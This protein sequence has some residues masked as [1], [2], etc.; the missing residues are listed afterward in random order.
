VLRLASG[1]WRRIAVLRPG[2]IG[3]YL[4]ATPAVRALR[5]AVPEARLDYVALPLIRELVERNPQ[6]DRFVAFPGFPSIAE[7]F[8][9]ARRAVR[10]LAAMQRQRYDLVLQL[11]GSGVHANPIALLMGPRYCAGFIRPE[12]DAHG[13]DEA[14]PLPSS[15]TEVDRV[16]ALTRLL[17][18]PDAGRWYDLELRPGDRAD[19]GRWLESLPR[20]VV[21]VHCGARDDQRRVEP[22]AYSQAAAILVASHGG[23]VAIL[24]GE[25]ERAAAVAL[26]AALR[27]AAVPYRDLAGRIPIATAAA[28]IAD[29]DVLLTTD[30]GPAHL[31]YATGTPSVTMFLDSE[32]QRWGPPAPGP[33][34]VLDCRGGS[35]PAPQIIADAASAS[36]IP[37]GTRLLARHPLPP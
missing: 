7:Q 23:A 33:H 35:V 3:D 14:L 24:G 30:S 8:F 1:G 37:C 10:W 29:V 19:A 31:A 9:D 21:G 11:Y 20:P 5:R 4:C 26:A 12:D 16:L 28:V 32:P 18:V 34:V 36:G 22:A 27:A 25:T 13:L 6:V 17:G 2:R 15:G